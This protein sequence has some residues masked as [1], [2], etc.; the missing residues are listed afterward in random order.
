MAPPPGAVC[1][2]LVLV[3][4]DLRVAGEVLFKNGHMALDW[5]RRASMVEVGFRGVVGC[6]VVGWWYCRGGGVGRE[7]KQVGRG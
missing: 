4:M 3:D 1:W 2:T 7:G 5:R 6:V